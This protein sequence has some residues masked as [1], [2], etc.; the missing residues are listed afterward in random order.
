MTP[1]EVVE[2]NRT[3]SSGTKVGVT[4]P[5]VVFDYNKYTGGVDNFD[6]KRHMKWSDRRSKYWWYR[7]VYFL[8]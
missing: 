6:Q 2:E 4:C 7:L 8:L 3:L 5:K 1:S